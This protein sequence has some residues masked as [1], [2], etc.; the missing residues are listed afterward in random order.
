MLD[1]CTQSLP[2]VENRLFP[3]QTQGLFG[4]AT[5]VLP[6]PLQVW[7]HIV[8]LGRFSISGRV[9]DRT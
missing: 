6:V 5:E 2:S 8:Q 1:T 4:A 9:G 7:D 3:P